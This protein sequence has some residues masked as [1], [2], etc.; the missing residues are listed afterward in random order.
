MTLRVTAVLLALC[1]CLEAGSPPLSGGRDTVEPA[2]S[3]GVP[4]RIDFPVWQVENWRTSRG[5]P[6]NWV[7]CIHQTSDGYLWL[8][9][10]DGLYRF[11]GQRFLRLNS[12]NCAAFESDVVKALAEDELGALWVATKRGVLCL[13]DGSVRHFSL[14]DGLGGEETTSVSTGRDGSVWVG[15]SGGASRLLSGRWQNFTCPEWPAPFVYCILVDSGGGVWA[16]SANGVWQLDPSAG[17]FIGRWV[18]TDSDQGPEAGIVRCLW[19]T[20]DRGLWFGT[21]RGVFRLKRG[22]VSPVSIAPASPAN[23]TKVL[24]EDR[25]SGLWAVIGYSLHRWG[26]ESFEPMDSRFALTDLVVNCIQTDRDNSLWVGT[27]YAG[28][29]R[30][31]RT[32]VRVVTRADGLPDSRVTAVARHPEGGVYVV[33]PK[34][35]CRWEAGHVRTIAVGTPPEGARLRSVFE[36]GEGRTWLTS[37]T[38]GL[39]RL[40]EPDLVPAGEDVQL[41]AGRDIRAVHRDR[42][43][44]IWLACRAGLVRWLPADS[45]A[46]RG[47]PVAGEWWLFNEEGVFHTILGTLRYSHRSWTQDEDGRWRASPPEGTLVEGPAETGFVPLEGRFGSYDFTA[48]AEQADGS[49]W[50]GTETG[51]LA[52]LYQRKIATFGEEAGL[53]PGAVT[54][55]LVD[56]RDRLWVGLESGI[57]V[58]VGERFRH[59]DASEALP[60]GRVQQ[61]AEDAFGN[62]WIG[63]ESGIHRLDAEQLL[64]RLE[65]RS[66]RLDW[67]TLD[68]T[69]GLISAEVEGEVQPGACRSDEGW[70][71]FPTAQGLVVIDPTMAPLPPALPSL[72]LELVRASGRVVFDSAAY[73]SVPQEGAPPS[74][75]AA[76]LPG[77]P[78]SHEPLRLQLT[79]GE[80][81]SLELRYCGLTLD[82]P[83][84]LR[85][86]YRLNGFE[87]D[88]I[89]ADT[90]RVA[91]YA[92]LKHGSYSFQVRAADSHGSEMASAVLATLT[93]AP[94]WYQ[95]AWFRIAAPAM[96]VLLFAV[97]LSWYLRQVSQRHLLEK[98][99]SL[100]EQRERIGRDL[101]DDL[102]N[103]LAHAVMQVAALREGHAT[104][105][106]GTNALEATESIVRSAY[107]TLR[108]VVW[109]SN[110]DQDTA[111]SLAR[112]ICQSAEALFEG[113]ATACRFDLPDHWPQA[114]LPGTRRREL[115]LAAKEALGNIVRHAQASEV[116]IRVQAGQETL[117]MVFQDNG[118]G[119]L[120]PTSFA[121]RADG[122]GNGLRNLQRRLEAMG[123]TVEIMSQPNQGSRITFRVPLTDPQCGRG[124][125][126]PPNRPGSPA[127][128]A[129]PVGP[130]PTIRGST[131]L[132]RFPLPPP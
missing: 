37:E 130:S 51:G 115:L 12:D 108:D 18:P 124:T 5:L 123:G 35:L 69:D 49:L 15:T 105:R 101:H 9:T 53:P 6:G 22:E 74:V 99:L 102:G 60:A 107:E 59:L 64:A 55:L 129:I 112:R 104:I 95:T 25:Q 72:H 78:P 27:R 117:L 126:P 120:P 89:Q 71:W 116:R 43:N 31:K 90:R 125:S 20:A 33:T 80:G 77:T 68:E 88:W 96:F 103:S 67:L 48:V 106:N 50:F 32:P 131:Q 3:V 92:N 97:A 26:G 52:R 122:T 21:D 75:P 121:P 24:F 98:E 17:E 79:A 81:G 119:F 111:Q 94:F 113:T 4:L 42:R 84:S 93:I 23:R 132:P 118:R 46:G 36:D 87:Q 85:F 82:A 65:G 62:L 100:R 34:A 19:E 1:R 47:Q 76:R 41:P 8:G 56:A 114:V 58:R 16:G 83:E 57:A 128:R 109:A 38:R 13:K 11:D 14:T 86:T 91:Y 39:S 29:S 70:L 54:S 40:E 66:N 63:G 2:D 127:G 28:V 44:G 10:P 7:E 45:P 110:P 61:L 73:R 30:L